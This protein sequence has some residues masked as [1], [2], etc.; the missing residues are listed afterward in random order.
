[1][2]SAR[3][4]AGVQLLF[5]AFFLSPAHAVEPPR[6]FASVFD[7]KEIFSAN[8]QLFPEWTGVLQRSHAEIGRTCSA[9]SSACPPQEWQDILRHVRDLSPR[10]KVEYVNAKINAHPYVPSVRNWG[11]TSYWETP[12]EFLRRN[13]QCQDYATTKF[14]LL[15]AAGVPNN[16]M[17]LVIT[18]DFISKQDHAILLVDVDGQALMLDNLTRDVVPAAQVHRYRPYY[19]INETGWW[20]HLPRTAPAAIAAL[21]PTRTDG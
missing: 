3:L 15:R 21:H 7:S 12:F 4:L 13:G 8:L 10:A 14:I 19:S 16:A 1:M 20:Q 5:A 18:Y 17:R 2:G 11:T 6:G 9:G